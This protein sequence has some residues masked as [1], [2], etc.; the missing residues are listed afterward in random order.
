MTRPWLPSPDSAAF[1]VYVDQWLVDLRAR[2]AS[3]ATLQ[4]HA[5]TLAEALNAWQAGRHLSR[6]QKQVVRT[7]LHFARQHE[8]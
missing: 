2:G 8:P 1:G 6:R 5:A 4:R 7:F 3:S